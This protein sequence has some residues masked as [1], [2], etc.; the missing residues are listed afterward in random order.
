MENDFIDKTEQKV[1]KLNS[2]IKRITSICLGVE[3]FFTLILEL[4]NKYSWVFQV[5]L[6]SCLFLI[7]I[8]VIYMYRKE[9][10]ELKDR[11]KNYDSN[12]IKLFTTNKTVYGVLIGVTAILFLFIFLTNFSFSGSKCSSNNIVLHDPVDTGR[13]SKLYREAVK[14]CCYP[15][16]DEIDTNLIKISYS[17]HYLK[18]K[19]INGQKYFLAVTLKYDTTYYKHDDKGNYNTGNYEN[20]ITAAP[21][22]L[23]RVHS[24]PQEEISLLRLKQLL[25]LAPQ[26][27][28]KYIIEFWVRKKDIFRPCMD[29]EVDDDRCELCDLTKKD[30]AVKKWVDDTRIQRYYSYSLN[31][32][33]PW[34][35]FGYTY[36]W[37]PDT[38]N[39]TGL[40]E[41]VIRKNA[42]VYIN[43]IYTV[44]EYLNL[45][46]L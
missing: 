28:Y 40:S 41:F 3:T 30:S 22:L 7:S 12:G 39:H 14:N 33:N 5:L 10:L 17:N 18:W 37:N 19:T 35:E 36:D 21:E 32:Q 20:W 1:E 16:Q 45:K 15:T 24:F 8:L 44:S 25:G 23:D 31:A 38:K 11:I 27:D 42:D 26:N 13:L 9:L 46:Q 2:L 29:Q 6:L 4:I 34:T 43:H